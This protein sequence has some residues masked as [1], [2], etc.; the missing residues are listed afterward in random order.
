MP[1]ALKEKGEAS[2]GTEVAQETMNRWKDDPNL[3]EDVRE[4]ISDAEG[5]VENQM[6]SRVVSEARCEERLRRMLRKS[7]QCCR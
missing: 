4:Y 3:T 6:V 2:I 1:C 5:Y 7:S